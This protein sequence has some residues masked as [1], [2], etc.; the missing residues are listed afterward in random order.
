MKFL[1]IAGAMIAGIF[2]PQLGEYQFIIRYLLMAMLFCAF[3]R[4]ENVSKFRDKSQL[5]ILAANYIIPLFFYGIFMVSG[6]KEL[7]AAAFMTGITPT[8]TAAPVVVAFLH[9]KIEY[10]LNT[11]L[12]TNVVIALTLPFLLP[13]L[14]LSE[15]GRALEMVGKLMADMGLVM[16]LPLA[17]AWILRKIFPPLREWAVKY[18][19]Y[20][21]LIW[22]VLIFFI[23]CRASEFLRYQQH[24]KLSV[25]LLIGG[26]SLL[27]CFLNFFIGR[28][29][30]GEKYRAEGSQSLGQKNTSFT[31]YVALFYVSPLAALGPMFYVLWHNLWNGWQ[32]QHAD[33][34]L[35][36]KSPEME[37]DSGKNTCKNS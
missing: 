3:L 10:V 28:L 33:K 34:Y 1:G 9:G 19:K 24:E 7:A 2:F 35:P 22:L 31:V 36:E 6:R 18:G 11:F 14:G 13:L 27:I 15:G 20:S 12:L 29:I 25:I 5:L 17:A 26:S 30:G 21:Y 4:M 32:I 23:I 16:F 8:A 37:P